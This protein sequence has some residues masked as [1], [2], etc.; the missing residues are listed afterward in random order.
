[1]I[2]ICIESS[3]AKGMGHLFRGIHLARC[4]SRHDQGYI[5]LVNDHPPAIRQLRQ[6][7][8]PFAIVPLHQISED[9]ETAAIAEY[10]IDIWINDR[11]DTPREHARRIKTGKVALAT[12]DDAGSGAS[13]SDLHIAPLAGCRQIRLEGARLLTDW[14]YLIM[15]PQLARYRH[16]RCKM[17]KLLVTLGGSDTHG[18][19]VSV[20]RMLK[21]LGLSATIHTGPGFEHDEALRQMVDSRFDCVS[22]I[23]SMGVLYGNH[24]L[25]ITGGGITPFE[26]AATGLPC[27]LIANED[28]EIPTCQS[29]E[30]EGVAC[31]AGHHRD[32]TVEKLTVTVS[33]AREH[34]P[35][36]SAH[37]LETMP[38]GGAEN[39]YDAICRYL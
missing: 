7:E 31:F 10:A 2:A 33:T 15:D 27:V 21:Q 25:A 9:W 36:M 38:A 32:L 35:A 19:V 37:C 18:V 22:A 16:H 30:A 12:F 3:H 26:A 17:D 34:L 13:L 28:F 11:L 24:D 4:L 6:L 1:M 29:L 39:V 5:I 14:R 23:P 20:V 8:L